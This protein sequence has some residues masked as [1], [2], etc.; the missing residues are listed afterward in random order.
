MNIYDAAAKYVGSR[1]RT[2]AE[3]R[4]HLKAKG[5]GSG[6]IEEVI[7]D[8]IDF[9]YL[10]DRGYCMDFFAYAHG[11]GWAKRRIISAL[12]EKG[13]SGELAEDAYEEYMSG[14]SE[15]KGE[16]DRAFSVALSMAK[17]AG[18]TG[19]EDLTESIKG[20]IGRRLASY[21]YSAGVF[22][23]TLRRLERYFDER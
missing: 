10:N 12:G 16:E 6:E 19:R 3:V 7:A 21:G 2:A 22:Y 14:D 15:E 18:V 4:K 5:Y 8:F 17:A 23:G 11:K 13:I 1:A 9:G 20:R